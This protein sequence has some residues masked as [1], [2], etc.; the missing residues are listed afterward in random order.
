M[1]QFRFLFRLAPA[2]YFGLPDGDR[3]VVPV[4]PGGQLVGPV[5]DTRTG[6]LVSH[7]TLSQYRSP[8]AAAATSL[9][10]G[11]FSVSLSDNFLHVTAAGADAQNAADC[12]VPY[13]DL[14]VQSL[15]ALYGQRFS[16]SFLSVED[17][18][19]FPQRV[20]IGPSTRQLFRATIY[21]TQ[22]VAERVGTA[23]TWAASVDAVAQKALFYFEHACLLQ[24]FSETL[25]LSSP[26]AVFSRAL[27]FLQLFKALT[28]IVGD[29]SS[30]RDYQSRCKRLGLGKD[31]WQVK[32]KPL[33]DI[34]NDDDVAH[35]SH[36]FPEPGAFLAQYAQAV[37]VFREALSAHMSSRVASAGGG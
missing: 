4:R 27:A 20:L 36:A 29:P 16:A 10:A 24:E 14:L 28:A 13:T 21:N 34:R 23:A 2:S 19:G 15:T 32:A 3:V 35:Y 22:E 1:P 33:Y 7:G 11:E 30:D 37:V 18:R 17:D 8:E 12:V 5:L 31:F 6:Q 26:H 25:P 9:V